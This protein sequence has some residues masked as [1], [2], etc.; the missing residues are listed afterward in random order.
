MSTTTSAHSP[1]RSDSTPPSPSRG[2]RCRR[3]PCTSHT[4]RSTASTHSPH[5]S[6][7]SPALIY[8]RFPG[9][10]SCALLSRRRSSSLKSVPPSR[11]MRMVLLQWY[12]KV[13]D[14][15]AVERAKYDLRW[16]AA[17]G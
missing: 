16:K 5:P 3:P 14:D 17:L 4:S 1:S 6:P 2:S 9:I 12:D 13:S 10:P 11:M 8:T 7:F 15:E